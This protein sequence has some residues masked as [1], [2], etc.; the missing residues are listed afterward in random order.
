MLPGAQQLESVCTNAPVRSPPVAGGNLTTTG[1]GATLATAGHTA[2]RAIL[3]T[4]AVC[5]SPS[6]CVPIVP[7]R[8]FDLVYL[9]R[10]DDATFEFIVCRE[11][12]GDVLRVE[13]YASGDQLL[14]TWRA[15]ADS[16]QR[17]E[18]GDVIAIAPPPAGFEPES[19]W[20]VPEYFYTVEF[21]LGTELE[22]RLVADASGS[23][24][25]ADVSGS[26]WRD[27][28]GRL[29]SPEC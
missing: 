3:A 26:E 4:V 21:V 9:H 1:L 18:E 29:T 24:R 6:S 19:E 17:F 14:E 23:F 5:V 15:D 25:G 2:A 20:A 8:P 27:Q 10:P 28:S 11:V 16:V 7:S 22:G 13:F 12:E